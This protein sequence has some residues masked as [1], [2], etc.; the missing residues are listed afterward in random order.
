MSSRCISLKC[1]NGVFSHVPFLTHRLCSTWLAFWV[2]LGIFVSCYDQINREEDEV[3]QDV[4]EEYKERNNDK[5]D[6]ADY[7]AMATPETSD[8]ELYEHVSSFKHSQ[9]GAAA[10][11][12]MGQSVLV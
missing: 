12:S 9:Q 1:N 2:S 7:K 5:V 6:Q 10:A 3:E 4:D 11:A 8:G